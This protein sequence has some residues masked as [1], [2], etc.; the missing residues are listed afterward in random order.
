MKEQEKRIFME[1]Y[2]RKL[3]KMKAEQ[4]RDEWEKVTKSLRGEK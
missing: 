2:K 4:L 3:S 1:E